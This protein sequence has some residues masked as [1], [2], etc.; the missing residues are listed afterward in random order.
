MEQATFDGMSVLSQN[1]F[2][3]QFEHGH[4]VLKVQKDLDQ[5]FQLM[6][7][8]RSEHLDIHRSNRRLDSYLFYRSSRL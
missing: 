2:S 1:N 3:G 6:D 7:E 4:E 5:F 8:L